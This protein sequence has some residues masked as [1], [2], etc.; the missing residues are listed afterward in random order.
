MNKIVLETVVSEH[1]KIR[2]KVHEHTSSWNKFIWSSSN[3]SKCFMNKR[4]IETGL[5]DHHKIRVKGSW[6]N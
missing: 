3:K 1:H 2:G 5:S 6:T 4:V